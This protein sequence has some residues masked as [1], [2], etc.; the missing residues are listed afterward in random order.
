M[1]KSKFLLIPLLGTLSVSLISCGDP[2]S[3]TLSSATNSAG[4]VDP[5]LD[6]LEPT[7]D[8]SSQEGYK[9]GRDLFY[10]Y[11]RQDQEY[12]I[13]LKTNNG[14]AVMPSRGRSKV[15]VV[16]V[17]FSDTTK[18]EQEKKPIID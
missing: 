3:S 10:Y 7:I 14:H 9:Y 12:N 1:N 18:T 8:V 2:V 6:G 15:L 17:L 13:A 16:P 4:F 11:N 5:A